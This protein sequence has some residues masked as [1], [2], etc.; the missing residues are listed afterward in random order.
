MQKT[1]HESD[2]PGWCSDPAKKLP[3][4]V[5]AALDARDAQ[6]SKAEDRE[7]ILAS[8]ARLDGGLGAVTTVVCAAM[9]EWLAA[10]GAAAVARLPRG[11]RGTRTSCSWTKRRRSWGPA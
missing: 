11:T 9:R 6:I 1:A 7:Y 8:V 5:I 10:E 4:K 2:Q 3:I